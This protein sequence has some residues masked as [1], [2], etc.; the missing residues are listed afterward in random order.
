MDA[1][2]KEQLEVFKTCG[3]VGKCK[4]SLR[5]GFLLQ[6]PLLAVTYVKRLHICYI[7]APWDRVPASSLSA[8]PLV[9][10][11]RCLS[12]HRLHRSGRVR[13]CDRLGASC[14]PQ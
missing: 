1:K 7:G 14:R 3:E 11:G 4:E 12:E 13:Q 5:I 9:A 2:E 10:G 6:A 8:C